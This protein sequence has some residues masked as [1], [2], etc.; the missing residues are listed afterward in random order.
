MGV[1]PNTTGDKWIGSS[2]M[3]TLLQILVGVIVL[4]LLSTVVFY[5]LRNKIPLTMH[6][7]RPPGSTETRNFTPMELFICLL[8]IEG[9]ASFGIYGIVVLIK[10]I[11]QHVQIV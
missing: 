4:S 10:F 11:V 2:Y 7:K 6:Y 5:P 8:I 1:T 3:V 9:I